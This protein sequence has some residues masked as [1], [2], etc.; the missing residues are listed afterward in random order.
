LV[1]DTTRF[2]ERR[3]MALGAGLILVLAACSTVASPAP[4]S[5]SL[6]SMSMPS[7]VST[8]P[9]VSSVPSPSGPVRCAVTPDASPSATIEIT[10][11]SLG[12]FHFGEPVTIK[13]G[14]AVVFTNGN[15]S[16]HT[17]TEG[18]SGEAVADACVDVPIANNA[19]VIVTFY[20]PGDYPIT[21][22]PHP[23]MQTS[24]LVE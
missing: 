7:T 20:Q 23:P 9:S 11:D 17:I 18:T 13:A 2:A 12:F 24:V 16:P 14:Q 4:S 22:R 5:S 15:G 21:C 6:P 8:A 19:S 3:W 10:A 1:P